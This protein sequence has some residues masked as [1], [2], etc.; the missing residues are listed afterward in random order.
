MDHTDR[1]AFF[2]TLAPGLL[3]SWA[4][5]MLLT[6]YRDYRDTFQREI[7]EAMGYTEIGAFSISETI[8]GVALMVM[9]GLVVVIQNNYWG[10]AASILLVFAGSLVLVGGQVGHHLGISGMSYM[11]L[12]GL[13]SYMGYV[14]RT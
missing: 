11:I 8:V 7:F 5:M 12:T 1:L 13:G 2:K 4:L 10:L 3:A 6:A 9:I 14:G